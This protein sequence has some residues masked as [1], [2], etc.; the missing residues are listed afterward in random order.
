MGANRTRTLLSLAGALTL[1]GCGCCDEGAAKPAPAPAAAPAPEPKTTAAAPA[2]PN[3]EVKDATPSATYALTTCVVSGDD[4]KEMG[5]P[6]A[7]TCD[8]TEVQ[9]CCRKCIATFQKD[10]AKYLQMV[11]GAKAK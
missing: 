9:F 3:Y 8:G 11:R 5:G 2:A 6:V 4:L 7:I 1:A 10:P